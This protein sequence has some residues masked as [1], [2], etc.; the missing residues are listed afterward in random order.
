[1]TLPRG[2]VI[3]SHVLGDASGVSSAA[4]ALASVP[5]DRP[6]RHAPRARTLPAA[7]LRTYEEAEACLL[8]A[9]GEA[10]QLV[11]QAHLDA[12][13]IREAA[14]KEGQQTAAAALA[15]GWIHL[16]AAQARHVTANE[17]KIMEIA[18]ILAEKLLGQALEL[19]PRLVV[20]LARE[21]V[22]SV[23]RA[24]RFVFYAHPLD[25]DTLDRHR[26]RLGLD[27]SLVDIESDPSQT[28]GSLRIETDLGV[29]DAKVP[30]QLDLLI[31]A[32]HH[33]A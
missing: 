12:A 16:H 3:P 17:Q 7:S 19:E 29:L 13:R 33:P 32:L 21:C 10:E 18:R 11:Q 20:D 9:R 15:A 31:E 8:R 5:A 30:Q 24:S 27:V 22:Q 1:M 26:D 2:R 6:T 4:T 25:A 23:Q 14:E 28:R